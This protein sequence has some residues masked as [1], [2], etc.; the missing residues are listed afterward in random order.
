MQTAGDQDD[1]KFFYIS[2][3]PELPTV[4]AYG[5]EDK[6]EKTVRQA[7]RVKGEIMIQF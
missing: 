5:S 6:K 4:W 3:R 7:S 2:T 1:T